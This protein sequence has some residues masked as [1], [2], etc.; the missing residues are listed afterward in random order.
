MTRSATSFLPA[1]LLSLCTALCAALCFPGTDAAARAPA[2]APAP[3][4][5]DRVTFTETIAPI[6]YAQCV[7][8]HRPGA[9]APFPL[10][11]YDEVKRRASLIAKVTRSRFMPP[12]QAAP[13]HGEFADERRLTDAQIAALAAWVAQGTPRG[14]RAKMPPLPAFGDGWQLG[15]PDLILEMPV[16]Y[17]VPASGPDIYRNFTIPTGLTEARWVRA[18]EFRPRARKA[19]HHAIFSYARAGA[20]A[21]L[22]E[23]DGEPGFAGLAPVSWR[24][25]YGPAGE[26]GT[27]TVGA[28]PR[29]IAE[30]LSLPLP[31]GSDFILQLHLHPTG[32]PETERAQI[33]LYLTDVPPDRAIMHMSAPGLFGFMAGID[34]PAGEKAYTLQG[35]LTMFVDMRALSVGAHAHYLGKDVRATATFPDGTTRPLLWIP[36]WD[37]NWQDRYVYKEPILLPKGTRIDVRLTYDNSADNPRN[38]NS[39]PRRVQWGEESFDEMGAVQFQMVAVRK[40]DEEVLK[41]LAAAVV[42]AMAQKAGQDGTFKRY[43]EYRQRK[44]EEAAARQRP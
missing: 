44:K 10:M 27:W 9:A 15:T 14:D 11:S 3:P 17:T 13:G 39:P 8:C 18:V 36:D 31:K 1:G 35:S 34:I 5:P 26:L 16:A 22:E 40:E 6:L 20:T 29:F 4:A 12:W 43:Q 23:T 25:G 33:G 42:K 37:F 28:T 21:E 2:P 19:V 38:P 41:K 24:P 30:G 7:T 32:K